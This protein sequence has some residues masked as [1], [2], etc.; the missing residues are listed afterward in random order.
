MIG[1]NIKKVREAKGLGL[2]QLAKL[3]G[4]N[5]SYLSALERGEKKNPSTQLINKLSKAL[6]VPGA[7][8]LRENS[9][10][11]EEI[12]G[13]LLKIAEFSGF[14][15]MTNEDKK[16]ALK[17]ILEQD[18]SIFYELNSD[19][20]NKFLVREAPSSYEHNALPKEAQKELDNFMEYLKHKYNLKGE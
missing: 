5:A 20:Q 12:S 10:T 7:L 9:D 11:V 18:P 13:E 15:D 14:D 1:N 4:V 19:L 3:A 8:L 16:Q 6:Q 2:N 17:D